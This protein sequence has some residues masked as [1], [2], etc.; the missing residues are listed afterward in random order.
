MTRDRWPELC[1]FVERDDGLPVRPIKHW[2]EDKLYFWNGY[3]HIT[4]TAM[5]GNPKW[6]AGVFYVD[7]FGGPVLLRRATRYA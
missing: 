1:E 7:L 6:P 3:I 4:T 5:V 2:T